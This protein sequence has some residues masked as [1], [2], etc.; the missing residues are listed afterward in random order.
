M[1]SHDCCRLSQAVVKPIANLSAKDIADMGATP[2]I[3]SGAHAAFRELWDDFGAF[4]KKVKDEHGNRRS[5]PVAAKAKAKPVALKRVT[6]ES[7]SQAKIV[8]GGILKYMFY[9]NEAT[10]EEL[11]MSPYEPAAVIGGMERFGE[12][13]D[14]AVPTRWAAGNQTSNTIFDKH[15]LG[16]IRIMGHGSRTFAAVNFG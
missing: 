11:W 10:K 6:D 14:Y 3:V 4:Q 15:M 13:Q 8:V 7:S 9:K 2:V 5:I 1:F 16:S 12:V